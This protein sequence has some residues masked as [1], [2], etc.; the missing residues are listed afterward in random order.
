MPV[1][2][3]RRVLVLLACVSA[4]HA[5]AW[6][7]V[8]KWVDEKGVTHYGSVPPPGAKRTVIQPAAPVGPAAASSAAE[9]APDVPNE[10]RRTGQEAPGAQARPQASVPG[11]QQAAAERLRRCALARQ[12]LEVLTQ[13]GPV[14][15]RDDKGGRQYL[16]DEARDGAIARL[17]AEVAQHCTGLDSDA[18]TKACW[19]E[20]DYFVICDQARSLLRAFEANRSRIPN[21]DYD[22]VRRQVEEACAPNRFPPETGRRG[23]W[24]RQY[25]LPEELR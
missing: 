7:Q 10:T 15:R 9:R 1:M 20:I 13:G 8:Y 21:Q 24:F 5:P 25:V 14:F 22:R 23:E 11:S 19:R 17:H 3:F 16:P 4:T 6:A 18:A 2:D 12:Q